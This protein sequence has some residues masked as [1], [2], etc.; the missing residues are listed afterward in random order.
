MIMPI[1]VFVC[2]Y[3]DNRHE[4]VLRQVQDRDKEEICEKCNEYMR[5]EITHHK[6]RPFTPYYHRQLEQHFSSR[7]EEKRYAK[8]NGLVNISSDFGKKISHYR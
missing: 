1:Y 4:F 8:K 3:C 5:R 2:K 6:T 7:D